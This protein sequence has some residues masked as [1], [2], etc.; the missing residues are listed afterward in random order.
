MPG[1]SAEIK[2]PWEAL[3]QTTTVSVAE[4]SQE[5]AMHEVSW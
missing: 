1:A 4:K 3:V 5:V 2:I